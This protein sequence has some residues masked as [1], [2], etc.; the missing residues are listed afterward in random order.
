MNR[1]AVD[2]V[3]Q[4]ESG[5]RVNVRHEV[6]VTE[7]NPS[8]GDGTDSMQTTDISLG[9]SHLKLLLPEIKSQHL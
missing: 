9:C 1:L 7:N 4:T 2:N 8:T 5:K 6:D 3:K